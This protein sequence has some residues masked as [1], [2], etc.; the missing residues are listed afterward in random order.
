[1]TITRVVVAIPVRDEEALLGD[2]LRAVLRAV[3][4]LGRARP[5][6][7]VEVVVALDRCVDR[8]AEVAAAFPVTSLLVEDG[9]VGAA[10][11]RAVAHGLASALA[12]GGE[13]TR[14]WVACTDGD[15]VVPATWLLTQLDLADKGVDLVIG[16]VEPV[17]DVAPHVLHAWHAR[18]QLVEGHQHVH[19][20][21]LGLRASAYLEAGGFGPLP[22]HEDVGIVRRIEGVGRVCVATD[23]TRVRTSARLASRLEGGF[24]SYL[25]AL[26][27]VG[28]ERKEPPPFPQVATSHMEL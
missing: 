12:H 14:T 3:T 6:V 15:T 13:T 10:R 26:A 11:D 23:R 4:V 21:N 27:R 1:M 22:V 28:R 24:A 16:T 19:G 9:R 25:D 8:S 17:G 2:A 7:G 5:E 20:A 18:H